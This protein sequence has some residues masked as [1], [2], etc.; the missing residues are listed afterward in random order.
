MKT[1]CILQNN[2]GYLHNEYIQIVK[3]HQDYF[4]SILE[5]SRDYLIDFFGFKTLERAYLIKV[6]KVIHERIQHLWLRVAIQIH[7]ENL[8]RV[9]ETYDGLS[10][11]YFI[12]ATP[13]LFNSGTAR[14]QLSSCYLLGMEDDS[15]D[16][17]FNT[18][19]DCAAISKWAG[20]IGLHIHNV[21]AQGSHI[22]GT[23]GTSNGIVPM[24]RVFNNTARYVDQGGGKRNGS[25]A[26]YLEPW[27]G[28]IENFLELRKNHGDEEARARD[29]FYA[30]WIPD[31]FMEKV[32]KNEDWY[33]MCPN[34]SKGL[35]DVWGDEFK[36]LY[37]KYVSEGKFIKKM[38][39]RD[40]WFQIFDFRWKLEHHIC[41]IMMHATK[42]QIK[43]SGSYQVFQS[44]H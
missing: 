15:I 23:N 4:E 30:L 9:K 18:L 13:T 38:K 35:H 34:I 36:T 14:P 3:K 10:Q 37:E 31:L 27:H 26:M 28:D 5:H 32:E 17:I 43:E 11:K 42:S 25:F 39:A 8:E 1:Q 22:I 24:L 2:P 40:L 16:G 21:R 7:K 6:N 44:L 20:G 29:L 41:C 12:H 19:K 33:L